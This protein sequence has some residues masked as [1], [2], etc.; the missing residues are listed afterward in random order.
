[1]VGQSVRFESGAVFLPREASWLDDLPAELLA[2]PSGRHDDQVDSISQALEWA[3][4]EQLRPQY[5]IS[6]L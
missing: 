6:R 1:M 5:R 2:F 4:Q 3:A